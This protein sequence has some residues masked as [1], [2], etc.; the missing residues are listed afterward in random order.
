MDLRLLASSIKEQVEGVTDGETLESDISKVINVA[1]LVIGLVAAIMIVVG[2]VNYM[3]A[4]G[5]PSK[6]TKGKKIMITG[7]VG[8]IIALLAFAIVNFVLNALQQTV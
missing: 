6:V 1:F 8:L 3:T 2:G 7:L 5:D 4:Q